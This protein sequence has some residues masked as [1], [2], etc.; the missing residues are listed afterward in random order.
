MNTTAKNGALCITCNNIKPI[1]V[2][3]ICEEYY[4]KKRRRL[5]KDAFF[6]KSRS[7]VDVSIILLQ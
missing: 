5:T 6:I 1:I 7:L 2:D 3:G 4:D